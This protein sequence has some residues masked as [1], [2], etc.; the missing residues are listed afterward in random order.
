MNKFIWK[1]FLSG[2]EIEI[3]DNWA[4]YYKDRQLTSTDQIVLKIYI[5]F[6]QQFWKK[7]SQF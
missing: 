7:K 6:P 4:W 2:I 5:G 3:P 1:F